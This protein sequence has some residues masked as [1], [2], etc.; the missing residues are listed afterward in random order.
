VII[1]EDEAAAG[2]ASVKTLRE[3]REQQR[4]R[5]RAAARSDP[6]P[7]VYGSHRS[8]STLD[9]KSRKRSPN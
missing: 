7:A 9:S 6:R 8:M 3:A 5:D 2:E 1:G 4:V